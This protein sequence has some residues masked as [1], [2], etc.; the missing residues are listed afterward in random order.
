MPRKPRPASDNEP[1]RLQVYLAR[2]GVASRRASEEL[3]R[4]GKVTVN[5]RVVTELGTKVDP[6][7]DK[8]TVSGRPVRPERPVWIALNKPLGYVTTRHDPQGR[9]T[10]Y[11]LIPKKLHHLFHVGRLDLNSEGLLLLTNEGQLANRLMHPRYGV[12]KEYLA[13]IAGTP[14]RQAL[15]RLVNGVQLDDGVAEAVEAE[16]LYQ[17]GPSGSRLRLVLQEGRYREVRRMLET[18]GHPVRG[19]LRIRFGPVQLQGVKK[20][21]WRYLSTAERQAM[22]PSGDSNDLSGVEL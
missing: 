1:I 10:V 14:S 7:R 17:G 12:T 4:R 6:A 9:P 5:G 22:Q 15:A 3:I 20:G 8:V 21:E 19:L 2:S 11:D 13:D 18:I 16:L